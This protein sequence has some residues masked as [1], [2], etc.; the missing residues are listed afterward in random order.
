MLL[1]II[2]TLAEAD[3]RAAAAADADAMQV[4]GEVVASHGQRAEEVLCDL[5]HASAAWQATLEHVCSTLCLENAKVFMRIL[6]TLQARAGNV[7][8]VTAMLAVLRNPQMPLS[9]LEA[10]VKELGLQRT[11]VA[12]RLLAEGGLEDV[13]RNSASPEALRAAAAKERMRVML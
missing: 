5:P 11:V 13:L 2:V 4:E 9:V 1:P 3:A 7:E 10:A 6:S 12:T 8:V